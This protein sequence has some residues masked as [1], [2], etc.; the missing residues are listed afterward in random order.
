MSSTVNLSSSDE[1]SGGGRTGNDGGVSPTATIKSSSTSSKPS[2]IKEIKET[3]LNGEMTFV[4]DNVLV[5]VPEEKE[6]PEQTLPSIS[7]YEWPSHDVKLK[8]LNTLDSL[9]RQLSSQKVINFLGWNDLNFEFNLA[10][11]EQ[12]VV[13]NISE[14]QLVDSALELSC[15]TALANWH[16]AYASDKGILRARLNDSQSENAT[17][18]LILEE[19]IVAHSKCKEKQVES[20]Q[21][22]FDVERIMGDAKKIA[23]DLKRQNEELEEAVEG[24]KSRNQ[25][26][27]ETV[28]TLKEQMNDLLA[29]NQ[30]LSQAGRDVRPIYEEHSRGFEK[31]MRQIPYMLNVSIE[32]VGFDVMK[33]IYNRELVPLKNIPDEELEAEI[34]VEPTEEVATEEGNEGMDV[35]GDPEG[36]NPPENEVE[37][38]VEEE[39]NIIN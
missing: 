6:D 32:E 36:V 37:D 2:N 38:A 9:P 31:A 16:L 39:I 34:T 29:F 19:A 1:S 18:K 12:G 30:N 11:D 7:G 13:E 22:L 26:L 17:L 28:V 14:K 5:E 21:L 23:R 33:D 4:Y 20:S 10:D 25:E 35:T 27:E 24:L 15:R 8:T 3:M